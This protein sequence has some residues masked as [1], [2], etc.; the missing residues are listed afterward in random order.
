[1]N[2]FSKCAES[3]DVEVDPEYFEKPTYLDSECEYYTVFSK[4][5]Y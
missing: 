4:Y 2:E 3:G 1:M 5:I